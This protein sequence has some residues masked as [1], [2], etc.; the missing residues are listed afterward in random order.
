[1]AGKVIT[2]PR[3]FQ[4]SL[5]FFHPGRRIPSRSAD[6]QVNLPGNA[7]VISQGSCE[8]ENENKN[9]TNYLTKNNMV[10]IRID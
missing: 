2:D 7:L 10:C 9:G 3:H 6:R 4:A 5:C 8:Q 1:M